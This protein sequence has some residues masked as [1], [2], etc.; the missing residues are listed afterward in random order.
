MTTFITSMQQREAAALI[1]L[2]RR[3]LLAKAHYNLKYRM[4]I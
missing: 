3:I 2:E 4:H 1:K